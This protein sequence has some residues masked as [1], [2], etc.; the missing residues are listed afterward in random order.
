MIVSFQGSGEKSTAG[1]ES[2]RPDS[3]GQQ[4]ASGVDRAQA[5]RESLG[6][7]AADEPDEEIVDLRTKDSKPARPKDLTDEQRAARLYP[8]EPTEKRTQDSVVSELL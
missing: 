8:K 2:N 5:P 3:T 7:S 4:P 1:E 6:G